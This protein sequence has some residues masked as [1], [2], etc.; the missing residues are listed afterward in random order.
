MQSKHSG[1][2]EGIRKADTGLLL[3]GV[4][5]AIVLALLVQVL[6]DLLERRVV[7]KGLRQAS[8]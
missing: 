7:S 8:H 5:P 1:I 3:E 4:L 2:L 6:F